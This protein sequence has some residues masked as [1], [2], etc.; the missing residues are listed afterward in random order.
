MMTVF[1]DYIRLYG[2]KNHTVANMCVSPV[3]F[4]SRSGW[5]LSLTQEQFVQSKALGSTR[6]TASERHKSCKKLR[7]NPESNADLLAVS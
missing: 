4:V 2:S 6:R 1:R 7:P 3:I 5:G